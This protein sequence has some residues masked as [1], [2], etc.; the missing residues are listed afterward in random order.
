MLLRLLTASAL[1][2]SLFSTG[3]TFPRSEQ[4]I[5]NKAPEG[6]TTLFD[7]KTLNGWKIVSGNAAYTVEDGCIVGTTAKNS[8]NT[9]LS[10]IGAWDN[11]ELAFQV[12]LD[13]NE[14][15]SGVQIRSR[16]I[17]EDDFGGRLGGPQ[18]EIEAGPGQ[19]G[20][21]Y[22]EAAGGWQ[23][24]DHERD[25]I[26]FKN[27]EWNNYNIV[28]RDNRITTWI[29]GVAIED[30]ELTDEFHN[31]FPSGVIGLQVHGVGDRGPFTVRWRNI[32]IRELDE[33]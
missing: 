20:L 2:L 25:H 19:A 33:L 7:G 3:C 1:A 31:R 15:N 29:N 18:V 9:F 27:G 10:T 11:F 16:I 28:A 23:S 13:D 6:W 4:S 21:I 32:Y 26:V 14:L 12:M 8:P 22:G 30:L 5:H 17:R 24:P